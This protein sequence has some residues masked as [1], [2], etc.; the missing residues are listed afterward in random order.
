M[1]DTSNKAA[2]PRRHE[3][4]HA[5]ADGT[6]VLLRRLTSADVA[7]IRHFFRERGGDESGVSLVSAE[8]TAATWRNLGDVDGEHHVAVAAFALRDAHAREGTLVGVA[9]FVR[10]EASRAVA[11]LEVSVAPAWKSRGVG[12]PLFSMLV[13]IAKKN[14][15]ES[16]VARTLRGSG[17]VRQ[18]LGR[19]G[20]LDVRAGEGSDVFEL[21]GK[22]TAPIGAARA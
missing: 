4:T 9:R 12:T 17:A 18:L 3:R 13:S 22:S 10:A 8:L 14:R 20:P 11:E 7:A 15:V 2:S 6:K 1:V 21:R 19:Q 5:L 16:L